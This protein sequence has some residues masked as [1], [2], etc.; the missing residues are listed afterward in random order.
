[1]RIAGSG[2]RPDTN[3]VKNDRVA[4]MSLREGVSEGRVP[5]RDVHR[6][7]F[8]L[9]GGV[10]VRHPA[11]QRGREIER[12]REPLAIAAFERIARLDVRLLAEEHAIERDVGIVDPRV[13][14][15]TGLGVVRRA[16]LR[17]EPD[18]ELARELMFDERR[19]LVR[20]F[21][22]VRREPQA[23]DDQPIEAANLGRFERYA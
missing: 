9:V 4:A 7:H 15:R 17:Y 21:A 23:D 18:A 3:V 10:R 22:G 14:C 6:P 16:A 1:M 5:E 11:Y 13:R 20:T 8:A 2:P 12:L 19:E